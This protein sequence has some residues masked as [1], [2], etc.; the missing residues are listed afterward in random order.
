MMELKRRSENVRSVRQK[1][2][3]KQPR[4]IWICLKSK[5]RWI[6]L[7]TRNCQ[8]LRSSRNKERKS[9]EI[10]NL[11]L[12]FD[13]PW[14]YYYTP[15]CLETVGWARCSSGVGSLPG[16]HRPWVPSLQCKSCQCKRL[17]FPRQKCHV[18]TG[19]AIRPQGSHFTVSLKIIKSLH[20]K[21]SAHYRTF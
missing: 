9:Q 20:L 13:G 7:P 5:K 21:T 18:T 4:R 10:S 2:G 12:A 1:T 15:V 14:T 11:A 17:A 3:R 6:F 16:R 8:L 19:D